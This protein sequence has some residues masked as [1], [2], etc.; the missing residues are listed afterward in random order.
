[1]SVERGD[2]E[3]KGPMMKMPDEHLQ[4]LKEKDCISMV[5]KI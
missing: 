5:M 1:M 2:A 3:V 4:R